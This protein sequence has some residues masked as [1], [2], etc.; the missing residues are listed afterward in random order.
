MA[1]RSFT[2]KEKIVFY[3][4]IKYPTLNDNA[5]SDIID[6]NPS[7]IATIRN[8]FKK[9]DYFRLFRI[10]SLQ[11]CGFEILTVSY[12]R[13]YFPSLSESPNTILNSI[14]KRI[15]NI[16][17]LLS[18][19]D[20]WLSLGYYQNYLNLKR[21]G[22]I[23]RFNKYQFNFQE[24]TETQII[25]PF[26]LT[27]IY[28]Y[29]DYS[30]IIKTFFE[31]DIDTKSQFEPENIMQLR[32]QESAIDTELD[33]TTKADN[34]DQ[35]TLHLDYLQYPDEPL[36]IPL[37]IKLTKAEREVFLAL[38][39]Y[40]ELSDFAINKMISISATSV[41]NIRKKF[42]SKAIIKQ[43]VVP[44]LKLLGFELIT[45]SHMKFKSFGNLSVREKLIQNIYNKIPS[46]LFISGNTDEVILAA[47]RNF[48]EYQ[49]IYEELTKLYRDKNILATE[50]RT[51]L[52]P[53][54][55]SVLIKEHSYVPIVNQ[56]LGRGKSIINSILEIIGEKLGETGKQILIK[57]LESIDILPDELTVRDIPKLIEIIE[58]IITP[59]FGIK[60]TEEI[61]ARIK[62]L[63]KAGS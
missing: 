25:F 24:D 51:L 35:S 63:E 43:C 9:N 12:D 3:G 61:S 17:F 26:G 60:S 19:P 13:L 16:F 42:E 53:L 59:I 54:T 29:F 18:A 41:N 22:E 5:L 57:H 28:N 44:N 21:I 52:F 2:E 30:Q 39:Q 56:L 23:V 10:P 7:T 46:I 20:S 50:P 55:E 48:S 8:K 47:H 15:P 62:Q 34:L 33:D 58:E 32:G 49:H 1:K 31:I 40:P 11:H 36:N 6:I 38:M 37:P 14:Y 27:R 45:L 4:M